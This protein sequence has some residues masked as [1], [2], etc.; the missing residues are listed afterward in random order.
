LEAYVLIQSAP[1]GE[2]LAR[3]LQVI[4]GVVSAQDLSGAFDAIALARAGSTGD[5]FDGIIADIRRLPG[6]TR[7]LPAPLIRSFSERPEHQPR[8][9]NRDSGDEAA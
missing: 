8:D 2:P 4:P 5:L 7:A 6:V 9:L 3:K 1:D